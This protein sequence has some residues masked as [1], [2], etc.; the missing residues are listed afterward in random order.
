MPRSLDRFF[1][2]GRRVDHRGD[3][4]QTGTGYLLTGGIMRDSTATPELG[5][6]VCVGLS[7]GFEVLAR[8]HMK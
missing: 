3:R 2:I 1:R 8:S 5:S 4:S 6:H 7:V